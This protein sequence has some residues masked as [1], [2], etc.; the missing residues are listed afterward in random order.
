MEKQE[1]TASQVNAI[2]KENWRVGVL[3]GAEQMR[4][5]AA[6]KSEFMGDF[7]I[8]RSIRA[9]PLEPEAEK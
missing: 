8:A 2:A 9:L 3:A 5:R 7:D 1:F 4:E 6:A